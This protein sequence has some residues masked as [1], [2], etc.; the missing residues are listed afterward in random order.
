MATVNLHAPADR[1]DLPLVLLP[2]F[3]LDSRVWGDVSGLLG[4]DVI[5]VD[6]PGFGGQTDS[7]PSLDSYARAVL[8]ALDARDVHRF[9]VAGNSVGGYVAI[10]LADLAPDRVAGLGLVGTKAGPG[11]DESAGRLAMAAAA[12]AG[13]PVAE[14]LA[15]MVAKLVSPTSRATV[16][17]LGDRVDA[18]AAEASAEGVA[19]L[20]RAMADRPDRLHV[21]ERTGVPA[22]IVYGLE[23]PLSSPEIQQEMAGA[24]GVEAIGVTGSGH[25]VPLENPGAVADALRATWDAARR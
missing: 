18:W 1:T 10:T 24:L 25:L 21:L 15:P 13:T 14:L 23:D 5:T 8:A 9:V 17:G 3:P 4:G 22:T 6:A 11:P 20:Q 2:P 16:P 12:D 19:W 7:D